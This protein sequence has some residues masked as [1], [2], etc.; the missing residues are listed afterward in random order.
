MRRMV[1][2]AR[3][4]AMRPTA[5]VSSIEALNQTFPRSRDSTR[6]FP[7]HQC[8]SDDDHD[9]NEAHEDE[10]DSEDQTIYMYR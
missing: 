7:P 5:W 9:E 6:D 10:D 3:R 1:V 2:V 4:E 8:P